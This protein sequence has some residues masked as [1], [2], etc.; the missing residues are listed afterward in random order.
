MNFSNSEQIN[1]T[2]NFKA[3]YELLPPSFVILNNNEIVYPSTIVNNNYTANFELNLNSN[4]DYCLKILRENH[5]E[6]NSQQLELTSMSVDG[7]DL[8]KI[9]DHSKY[10]PKYPEPWYTEQKDQGITLP[11]Y[12]T[13]SLV[14]GWN[15]YWTLFYTT[16]FYTWLLNSV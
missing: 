11:E 15:G 16:P 14:W 6:I 4:S 9:L 7:I 1:F 10:F 2:V 13:G 12:Q 5:D 3:T 8:A